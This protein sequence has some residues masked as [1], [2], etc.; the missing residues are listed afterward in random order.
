MLSD[1]L[2]ICLLRKS[3]YGLV[4]SLILLL[5][6]IYFACLKPYRISGII[7]IVSLLWAYS[8]ASVYLTQNAEGRPAVKRI[9]HPIV[10]YDLG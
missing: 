8:L 3:T 2:R 4:A 1:L 10:H 7:M 5:S 6:G 9:S